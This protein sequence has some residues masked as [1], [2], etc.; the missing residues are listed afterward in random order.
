MKVYIDLFH[1]KHL[2]LQCPGLG[3]RY[4]SIHVECVN[5]QF[6]CLDDDEILEK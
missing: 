6:L 4:H 5:N 2:L 3:S 1:R